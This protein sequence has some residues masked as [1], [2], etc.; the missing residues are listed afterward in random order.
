MSVLDG[1][2]KRY[3]E[4]ERASDICVVRST[5]T[6]VVG[7]APVTSV[8]GTGG[9]LC[10]KVEEYDVLLCMGWNGGGTGKGP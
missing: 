2:L 3:G 6:G 4:F 8:V 1:K 7:V 10:A 9:G 5:P